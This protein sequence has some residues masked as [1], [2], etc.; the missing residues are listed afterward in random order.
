MR[1]IV[2]CVVLAGSS[3]FP[4]TAFAEY[5]VTIENSTGKHVHIKPGGPGCIHDP[6]Y[7]DKDLAAGEKIQVHAQ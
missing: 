4:A 1:L 3:L 2:L 7:F 5:T 6:N